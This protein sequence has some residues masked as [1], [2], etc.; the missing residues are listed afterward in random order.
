M[1]GKIIK[2]SDFQKFKFRCEF[3]GRVKG[4][5]DE[6]TCGSKKCSDKLKEYGK[7]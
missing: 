4:F 3:C 6:R 2:F 7:K 5:G 1:F